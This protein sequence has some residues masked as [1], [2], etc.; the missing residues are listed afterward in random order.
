LAH[1]A[2]RTGTERVVRAMPNLPARVGKG[3]TGWVAS[4]QVAADEKSFVTE[5]FSLF[6]VQVPLE[7]EEMIDAFTAVSGSGP[8]YFFYLAELLEEKAKAFG[9]S[10]AD[11][12]ML[13]GQTFLGA[14]AIFA[15]GGKT[16][17]EWREAVTS[18]GGTT[19]AAL[20]VLQEKNIDEIMGAALN[21]AKKRSEELSQG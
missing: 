3:M 15:E 2:Q 9:F 4:E 8:A 19:E 14:A 10:D 11:A 21:A 18:K 1:L 6:G 5:L 7:K 12:R 16:A 13:A 17:R 20:G